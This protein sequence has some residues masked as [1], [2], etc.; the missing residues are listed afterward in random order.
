MR[1]PFASAILACHDMAV[2]T[3]MMRGRRLSP[4]RHRE[5]GGLRENDGVVLCDLRGSVVRFVVVGLV[6]GAMGAFVF[7]LYLRRYMKERRVD[8]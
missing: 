5:H 6:V 3:W 1:L 7:G 2:L 4:R 8:G